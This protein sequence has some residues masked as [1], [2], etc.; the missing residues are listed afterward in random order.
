MK[1]KVLSLLFSMIS[2][3]FTLYLSYLI[4]STIQATELMWFLWWV[5]FF[6]IITG[7]IL[8]RVAEWEDE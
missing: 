4:L 3:P 7:A 8:S 5:Q 2:L 6:M 1:V